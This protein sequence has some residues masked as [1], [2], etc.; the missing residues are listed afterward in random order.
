MPR[1]TKLESELQRLMTTYGKDHFLSVTRKTLLAAV[2][3]APDCDKEYSYTCEYRVNVDDCD[4]TD[5]QEAQLEAKAKELAEKKVA[6]LCKRRK[7]DCKSVEIIESSPTGGGC[8]CLTMMGV[9]VCF[10]TCMWT[11]KYK[12]K[13]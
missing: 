12:C 1:A 3:W 2:A 13:K 9:T 4:L 6:K 10:Y 11:V 5:E 8:N 7:D